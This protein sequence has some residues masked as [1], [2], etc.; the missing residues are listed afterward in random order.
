VN[1]EPLRLTTARWCNRPRPGDPDGKHDKIIAHGGTGL[2]ATFAY[3]THTDYAP[4]NGF[5]Y[6]PENGD[7]PLEKAVICSPESGL[8][9]IDVD[10]AEALA[11]SETGKLVGRA[12]AWSTRGD[13][14][15]IVLDVRGVDLGLIPKMGPCGWGDTRWKNFLPAPGSRHYTGET[16]APTERWVL[17]LDRA[18]T[19]ELLAAIGADR[20][21]HAEALKAARAAARK[22]IAKSATPAAVATAAASAAAR[23]HG[24]EMATGTHRELLLE[25]LWQCGRAHMSEPDAYAQWLAHCAPWEPGRP[26]TRDHFLN[27]WSAVP[28]KVAVREAE[29]AAEHGPQ[30]E[31]A[32]QATAAGKL[33]GELGRGPLAG[34]YLRGGLLTF[35]P[36]V[37]EDGYI[38]PTPAEAARGVDHGPAQVR[39]VDAAR[40]RSLI[41]VAFDVGK[42]VPDEY[43]NPVWVPML[44]PPDA[45]RHAVGAAE[46]GIGC[47]NLAHLAGITHTPVIRPDGSV[48]ALPGYD[49]PTGLLY[50]PPTGLSVPWVPDRPSAEQVRAAARLLLEP[51]AKFP[52]V[53]E[54]HRANFLGAMFTPLLRLMI[55][56]PYQMVIITATNA[57]SGKTLLMR[58]LGTIHGIA[59]RGE[60][61]REREELRKLFLSTLLTTTAP[62]IGMD[63][64]RGTIYSSELES[65]LT[66]RT[67]TDRE[68]G[69]SRVVTVTND[70]LW[71]TTGNNA[72]V[73]GDL[74]RRCLPVAL[75]PACADP[76]KRTF[77]F[78]PAAWMTTRRG[79]YI[80]ALLT[81]ASGWVQAKAPT[82]PAVRG[83]DYAAWYGALRGL[84]SWAGLPGEFGAED[85]ADLIAVAEDDDEWGAF[86]LELA[87]AF[88]NR[89][90]TAADVTAKMGVVDTPLS[91]ALPG[92]LAEKWG[93]LSY[94]SRG[95]SGFTRSL[96]K[97]LSYRD[98]RFTADGF[99][100]RAER[101]AHRVTYAVEWPK[102]L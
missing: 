49:A 20:A 11:A 32:N 69:V 7:G 77:A 19:I 66:A 25:L 6:H 75:D 46:L 54:H 58:L 13:H 40:L 94:H 78:D 65:L 85:K 24:H 95:S 36:R 31:V 72:R 83:D 43:G 10:N 89:R 91:G 30:F 52:F 37:G 79:E 67:L 90:F 80:A 16:Y 22:A 2:Y 39:P 44:F 92:D 74:A 68:L 15:H 51:I 28:A 56:P 102:V 73:S 50:L 100:I 101:G 57:G 21:R 45:A 86:V 4:G 8:Y 34:L 55:P 53:A 98:G 99:V 41:E 62:V 82:P 81:V 1:A 84:L 61:P 9:G 27:M 59:T 23:A 93:R 33:R 42:E 38:M 70:R 60:F 88:P 48:L 76:W 71:V 17:A 26:W 14:F 5:G 18:A 47:P 64:V 87:R 35:T 3:G 97:W 63:N 12:D 29:R 96:S